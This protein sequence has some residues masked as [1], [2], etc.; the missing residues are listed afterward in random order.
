ML[1]TAPR[2]VSALLVAIA[3]LGATQVA[4]TQSAHAEECARNNPSVK[5]YDDYFKASK[6]RVGGGSGVTLHLE[7]GHDFT[8]SATCTQLPAWMRARSKNWSKRRST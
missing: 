4:A 2:R 5:V 7:A 6:E 3:C 1:N 8:V